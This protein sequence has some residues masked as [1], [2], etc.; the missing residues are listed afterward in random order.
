VDIAQFGS[1]ATIA[2]VQEAADSVGP[3]SEASSGWR[4]DKRS[5]L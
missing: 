3:R 5:E 1:P 2:T 4:F